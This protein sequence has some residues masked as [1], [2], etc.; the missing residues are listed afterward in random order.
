MS[1]PVSERRAER[2]IAALD[3]EKLGGL[4]TVVTQAVADGKVLMLAF[5]SPEAVRRTLTQGW[6]HY[7]SRSREEIWKKGESSG[8]LQRVREVRI[9]CDGDA[10]LYIVEQEGAACHTGYVSCFYRRIEEDEI[11]P[12]E[13]RGE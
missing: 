7:Y 13:A 3:F 11:R 9:D 12:V 2:V 4:V 10:L 5:A 6:A 1:I 8:H